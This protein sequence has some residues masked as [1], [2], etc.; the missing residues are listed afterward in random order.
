M[1]LTDEIEVVHPHLPR[2]G[3]RS[4][5]FDF[6][7]TLSLI[8]EGWPAIMIPMM[9]E[10]L[11]G[12][13]TRETEDELTRIVEAFVMRLTGR[14]TIYQM[15]QLAEEVKKRGGAPS[16]PLEYKHLYHDR[17]MRRIHSR[18]QDLSAAPASKADWSVPGSHALLDNL[19]KRGVALYLASGTDIG[20]VRHEAELLGMTGY[21]GPHVYGALDDYKSFSKKMIVEKI[22][23][24][25]G[26]AGQQLIGFGDGYVEIEE[27]KRVGG[28]AVGVAS[29]EANRRGV[30]PW[31]R[32]R[33]IQ[34]GADIIIPE[35]RQQ[36][37]LID[38]L[39]SN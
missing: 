37:R 1:F 32:E 5:I 29:D 4:A 34:A 35:Y 10:I 16:D 19:K 33:L 23:R 30:D 27:V 6:D 31:K 21:F 39:F 18:I 25:N 2:G 12:T 8:R 17:L 20:Y 26:L 36:D 24:E 7:G 13:G 22:L 9:V 15:I 14:Q 38:W 3:I 28:I 11:Q